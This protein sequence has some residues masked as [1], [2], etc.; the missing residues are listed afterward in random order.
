MMNLRKYHGC[1]KFVPAPGYELY[2][3]PLCQDEISK[4]NPHMQESRGGSRVQH[5]HGPQTSLQGMEWRSING[6]FVLV[7]LN[8]VPWPV[9]DVLLAPEA[10]VSYFWSCFS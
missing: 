6:P 7:Y 8:N 4:D 5:Y 10:K 3:E 1:V 9:E 2:G